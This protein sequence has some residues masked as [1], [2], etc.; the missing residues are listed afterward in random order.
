[1]LEHDGIQEVLPNTP[2]CLLAGLGCSLS[3]NEPRSQRGDFEVA[4]RVL[5]I[6]TP[7]VR[8]RIRIRIRIRVCRVFEMGNRVERGENVGWLTCCGTGFAA[9]A[10][11]LEVD[12]PGLRLSGDLS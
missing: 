7:R 12:Y 4:D 3:E 11:H 2:L 6:F 5:C 8:V 10:F 1:M 9:A